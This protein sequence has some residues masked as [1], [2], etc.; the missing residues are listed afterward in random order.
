MDSYHYYST[1]FF[2]FS[3]NDQNAP[4]R[5][6]NAI[7]IPIETP[8]SGDF[9][10]PTPVRLPDAV[11]NAAAVKIQSAFRGHLVRSLV[12][13]IR[14]VNAESGRM[15]RL[16]Q[17][18]ETVD[19]VRRDERERLRVNEGLMALLL[20]LDSVPGF[21]PAVRELR[22]SVSRRIVGLQEVLDAILGEPAVG[23]EGFPANLEEI[24][25]G[26]WGGEERWGEEEVEE[27]GTG[28]NWERGFGCLEKLLLGV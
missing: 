21:Y 3:Q 6:N 24:V 1:S 23:G 10:P 11:P 27:M 9:P 19:A 5:P 8:S 17:R 16:I 2:Y 20:R 12:G 26:I 28:G 14:A 25:E 18:Q 4:H 15:E 22:R 7:L 13:K